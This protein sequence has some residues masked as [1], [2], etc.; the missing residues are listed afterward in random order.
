MGKIANQEYVKSHPGN[1]CALLLFHTR[2]GKKTKTRC[3][4]GN[5]VKD[6]ARAK[7]QSINFWLDFRWRIHQC[8][9]GHTP[10]TSGNLVTE[11]RL[12]LM[13]CDKCYNTATQLFFIRPFDILHRLLALSQKKIYI[14]TILLRSRYVILF[15]YTMSLCFVFSLTWHFHQEWH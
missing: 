5:F 3:P 12:N 6:S 1:A 8:F 11:N 9:L 13:I 10:G 4:D 7:E 14:K 2:V 15:K